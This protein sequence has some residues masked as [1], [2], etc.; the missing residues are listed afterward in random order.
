MPEGAD[1]HRQLADELLDDRGCQRAAKAVAGA[2]DDELEQR[3]FVLRNGRR[4]VDPRL[5]LVELVVDAEQRLLELSR[6]R[7]PA[8]RL[9][10]TPRNGRCV[11]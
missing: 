10:I 3:R 6:G 4:R 2:D 7:A 1:V 5:Q 8:H 11:L 9:T